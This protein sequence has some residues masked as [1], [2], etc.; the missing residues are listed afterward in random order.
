MPSPPP[1]LYL[2]T[3]PRFEPAAFVDQLAAA[4]DG[5]E[6]ACVRLRFSDADLGELRRAASL[7]R[8]VCHERGVAMVIEDHYRMVPNCG[9]DGAHFSLGASFPSDARHAVG[10][11]AI[12]GVDC[13]AS[14]HRGLVAGE[15][16]ADY[17]AFG[18]VAASPEMQTS[19][20]AEMELFAWWQEMIEVPVVAEGGVTP[21]VAVELIGVADFI[22]I[23]RSVWEHP[24][25]P[26]AGVAAYATALKSKV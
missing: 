10:A 11:D 15:R 25:G 7:L 6:V 13:G 20:L 18:P 8:P 4:L 17:V 14:R 22:S 9:L 3:P 16:G 24:E 19:G 5:A 12:L 26:T 1:R 23:S 2:V 21:E